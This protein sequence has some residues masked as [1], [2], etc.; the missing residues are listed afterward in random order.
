MLASKIWYKPEGLSYD[1]QSQENTIP[2]F[3]RVFTMLSSTL[4]E[5][6]PM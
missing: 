2:A 3:L 1:G 4:E 5:N 6:E